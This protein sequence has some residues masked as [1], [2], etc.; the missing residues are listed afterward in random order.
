M[1]SV[2]IGEEV[3]EPRAGG[4]GGNPTSTEAEVVSRATEEVDFSFATV[5]LVVGI[6]VYLDRAREFP[7][8]QGEYCRGQG[9]EW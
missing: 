7:R 3:A 6:I 9:A 4:A 5:D 8:G 1:D 2:P